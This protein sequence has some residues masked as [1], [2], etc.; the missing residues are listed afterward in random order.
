MSTVGKCGFGWLSIFVTAVFITLSLLN[1]MN[2]SI[3]FLRRSLAL[4]Q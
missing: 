2:A 1:I 4:V 3:G